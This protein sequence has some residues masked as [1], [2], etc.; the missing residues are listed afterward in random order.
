MS[1][2]FLW[3][4]LPGVLKLLEVMTELEMGFSCALC[5]LEILVYGANSRPLDHHNIG[6]H[7]QFVR[8]CCFSASNNG[9]QRI[10]VSISISVGPF[11]E[12]SFGIGGELAITEEYVCSGRRCL[13]C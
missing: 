4:E 5:L 12:M 9:S 10:V 13:I 6:V 2:L 11:I 7:T 3:S 8:R 1:K